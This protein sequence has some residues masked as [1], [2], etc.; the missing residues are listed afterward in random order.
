VFCPIIIQSIIIIIIQSID[1]CHYHHIIMRASAP[2]LS[3]SSSWK[4]AILHGLLLY[5][6]HAKET[7]GEPF[8]PLDDLLISPVHK[9]DQGSKI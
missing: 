3:S 1:H 2:S 7:T 8:I 5:R 6:V 4:G 9:L